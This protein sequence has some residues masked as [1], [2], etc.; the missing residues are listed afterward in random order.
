M[1]VSSS[2]HASGSILSLSSNNSNNSS[3]SQVVSA[4]SPKGRQLVAAKLQSGLRTGVLN[5]ADLD[6]RQAGSSSGGAVWPRLAEQQAVQRLRALDVSGNPLKALPVEVLGLANLKS[7]ATNH[8]GL[9]ST[10]DLA[11]ALVRLQ[12]LRIQH[13]DLEENTLGALPM[14]ITHLY[15]S[16]NH[17]SLPPRAIVGLTAVVHLDLS[18]N[19]LVS[20]AGLE[21]MVA[22][23]IVNVDDNLLCELPF[24]LSQLTQLKHISLKMNKLQPR[25]PTTNE[26]SIPKSI[27]ELTQLEKLELK[28][29]PMNNKDVLAFDGIELLLERRKLV[30]DKSFQGGALSDNSLFDLD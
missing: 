30:K 1:G 11:M 5:L 17:F 2:T 20:L 9:Q 6:L 15:L 12:T 14:S 8:C 24:Q 22:L 4:S 7:L 25:S 16:Y 21:S 28:G 23:V 26:Q 10:P 19:R 18:G 27:F 3:S 13:N 29:N